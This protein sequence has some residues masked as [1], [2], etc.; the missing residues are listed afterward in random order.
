MKIGNLHEMPWYLRL[1]IFGAIALALYGGF[2]Y[3]MTS[4]MHQEVDQLKEQVAA[5]TQ[6]NMT[7]QVDSQ[8]LA[9]FKSRYATT[10]Q[11]YEDLKA[12][13]P[14][15][16]E[17][18]SV[19]QGVQDRAHS[20]NL[21]LKSFSPKDDFE[22][23]FYNGKKISVGVTSS[24]ASLREFFEMMARYQRIVS[25]SNFE[26]TQL[27]KQGPGKTIDAKFELTAYYVSAESLQKAS[28]PVAP[29][30]AAPAGQ[31]AA[32]TAPAQNGAAPTQVGA[33]QIKIPQKP[34]G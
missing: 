6:Q 22:Q 32:A 1:T 31:P 27:D 9:E 20:S 29:G 5:L 19:L 28:A 4:G 7:A 3:F 14:E 11:E 13:L 8:R 10:Q 16:R 23:G 25:I 24:F 17:L 30:A 34:L 33:P 12:L 21:V 26:I 15:Q 2:W 18:T